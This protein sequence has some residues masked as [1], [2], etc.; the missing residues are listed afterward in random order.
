LEMRE[1]ERPV[2]SGKCQFLGKTEVRVAFSR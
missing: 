2:A 1:E